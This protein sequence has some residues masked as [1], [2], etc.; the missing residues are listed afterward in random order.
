M[1]VY[2]QYSLS[3]LSMKSSFSSARADP[4]L[5]SPNFSQQF[6]PIYYMLNDLFISGVYFYSCK[7]AYGQHVITPSS[8]CVGSRE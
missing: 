8:S 4:F 6:G 5:G 2:F 3:F 1:S 7:S